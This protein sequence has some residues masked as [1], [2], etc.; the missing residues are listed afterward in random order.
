MD[1]MDPL[2]LLSKQQYSVAIIII[3]LTIITTVQQRNL[4]YNMYNNNVI[5]SF[6]Q[7]QC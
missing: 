1:I 5:Y 7:F 4:K 2:Q 3:L 6:I